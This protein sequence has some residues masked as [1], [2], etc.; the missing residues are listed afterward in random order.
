MYG[1]KPGAN[2]NCTK[3]GQNLQSFI[4]IVNSLVF[5]FNFIFNKHNCAISYSNSNTLKLSQNFKQARMCKKFL[6]LGKTMLISY[7]CYTSCPTNSYC[8]TQ[9]CVYTSTCDNYIYICPV[10]SSWNSFKYNLNTSQKGG[11]S[12]QALAN[13]LLETMDRKTNRTF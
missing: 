4:W 7:A 10:M 13:N 8:N 5:I 3:T 9:K 12:N 11:F 2:Y 1:E 6:Q